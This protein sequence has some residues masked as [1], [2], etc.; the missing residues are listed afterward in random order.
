MVLPI[1]TQHFQQDDVQRCLLLLFLLLQEF[2]QLLPID[3]G[4]LAARQSILAA[5]AAAAAGAR[6]SYG[7]C[8]AAIGLSAVT[9]AAGAAWHRKQR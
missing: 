8:F 2:L 5:A 3:R 9:R 1:W 6:G 7:V 4:H